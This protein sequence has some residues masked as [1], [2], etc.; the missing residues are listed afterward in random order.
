MYP[1]P[2]QSIIGKLKGGVI[3]TITFARFTIHIA[4]ED[5]RA[6][7]ISS[8]FCFARADQI[9]DSAWADFPLSHS[10]MLRVLGATIT[11][12]TTDAQHHLTLEF[13]TGDSLLVSWT[14][15]YESYE[16]NFDGQRIVV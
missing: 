5:Q 14:P 7:S 2:D 1:P 11:S 16:L 4:C 9:R 15:Q 10:D 8:P 13:S 12:A 3:D 6:F